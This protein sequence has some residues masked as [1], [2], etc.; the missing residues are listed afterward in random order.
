MI[1]AIERIQDYTAGMDYARFCRDPKTVDAVV[2]NLE[3]IGEASKRVPKSLAAL[4]TDADWRRIGAMRDKLIHDY[5]ETNT[6]LVWETVQT[7][8]GSLDRAL[9]Q[10]LQVAEQNDRGGGKKR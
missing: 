3:I 10:M 1:R 5:A 6:G 4:Y 2:R 7:R 9:R 8:L